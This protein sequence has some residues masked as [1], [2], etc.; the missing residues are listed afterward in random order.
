MRPSIDKYCITNKKKRYFFTQSRKKKEVNILLKLFYN[1]LSGITRFLT[2]NWNRRRA[3][4]SYKLCCCVTHEKLIVP[5][6]Y[7]D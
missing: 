6:N 3:L 2:R 4:H 1:S 5:V 7:T